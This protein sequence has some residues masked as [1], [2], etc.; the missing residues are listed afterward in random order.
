[1]SLKKVEF[2]CS[3]LDWFLLLLVKTGEDGLQ[4]QKHAGPSSFGSLHHRTP[5]SFLHRTVDGWI[6]LPEPHQVSPSENSL[7]LVE[8][9]LWWFFF[10]I[11]R[12]QEQI[13]LQRE[14]IERQKKLLGK[15]K[16][17]TALTP[18]S[19]MEPSKRKSRNSSQE[20]ETSVKRYVF[21]LLQPINVTHLHFVFIFFVYCY[22][23]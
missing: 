3:F 9:S 7:S 17:P 2:L 22:F 8:K 13:N 10:S 12:Q 15:R 14:D 6:R 20:N 18:P 21:R 1:M 11:C 16:P 4:G 5:R 19:S 23:F